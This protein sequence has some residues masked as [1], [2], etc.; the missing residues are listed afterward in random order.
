MNRYLVSEPLRGWPQI[1]L[2]ERRTRLD[3]A[4]CIQELVDVHYPEA[5]TVVLVLDQLN[6]H[7]PASLYDAFPPAEAKRLADKPEIHYLPKQGS[8]LKWPRSS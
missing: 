8:W 6:T 2:S 4:H 3:W 1:P 5:E 7:S